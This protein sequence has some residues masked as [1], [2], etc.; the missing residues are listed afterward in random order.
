ME[1]GSLFDVIHKTPEELT[2]PRRL[3]IAIDGAAGLEYLHSLN[4]KVVHRDVKSMNVMIGENFN[5]RIGDEQFHK[6]AFA[7]GALSIVIVPEASAGYVNLDGISFSLPDGIGLVDVVDLYNV[8]ADMY[9]E[10]FGVQRQR[11]PD[12]SQELPAIQLRN[13]AFSFSPSGVD[14]SIRLRWH[15]W[16]S[17]M[18]GSFGLL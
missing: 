1:R 2:W 18:I 13:L 11:I 17:S 4:P 15:P 9:A 8:Y 3:K 7:A 12:I 16:P 10:M 14:S 6:E 5:A